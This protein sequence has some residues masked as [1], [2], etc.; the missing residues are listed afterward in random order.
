MKRM[1]IVALW[2]LSVGAFHVGY[3]AAR[4]DIPRDTVVTLVISAFMFSSCGALLM[5]SHWA[6]LAA[7]ESLEFSRKQLDIVDKRFEELRAER[8]R[9]RKELEAHGVIAEKPELDKVQH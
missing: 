1:K 8:Y 6:T 5:L 3:L 9:F 2:L 4:P 7:E